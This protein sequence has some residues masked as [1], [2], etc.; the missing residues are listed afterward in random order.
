MS[1]SGD[2][3]YVKLS[4]GDVHRVTLD[5]LDEAFQAGH[6]DGETMV[7]ASGA[8]QWTKLGALA[9]I[10]DDAEEVEPIESAPVRAAPNSEAPEPVQA[11][12][13]APR[14]TQDPRPASTPAQMPRG[15]VAVANVAPAYPVPL[16]A[17]G[18]LQIAQLPFGAPSP[19]AVAAG[20]RMAT[21]SQIPNPGPNGPASSSQHA[22]A[23]LPTGQPFVYAQPSSPGARMANGSTLG[24]AA[25]GPG[26]P[27]LTSLRPLSVDF[28]EIDTDIAKLRGG[29]GKRWM[30]LLFAVAVVGSLGTVAVQRPRWA[31]PYLAR[32]GL[33]A[34][35]QEAAAGVA[36]PLPPPVAE[37]TPPIAPPSATAEATAPTPVTGPSSDSPLSPHFTDQLTVVDHKAHVEDSDKAKSK[38][39]KAHG[40]APAAAHGSS[41]TKSKSTTFT[42]GGSKFDPL[43][44]SI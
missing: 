42:T 27:I 26:S 17:V 4:D 16:A 39:H 22:M 38:K 44:S 10:D 12:E 2:H 34:A 21:P 5:Q 25:Q 23:V 1:T 24:F 7:L 14:A 28:G 9:G 18:P 29:S 36:A 6:I 11:L 20:R 40:A 3:W 13:A 41:P 31:Q 15:E 43:N 8:T 33:R 30:G 19:S 32:V 37:P 35:T